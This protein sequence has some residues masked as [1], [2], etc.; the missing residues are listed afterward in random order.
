[1]GVHEGTYLEFFAKVYN[2]NFGLFSSVIISILIRNGR[3]LMLL[4]AFSLFL[5]LE[6]ASVWYNLLCSLLY[7]EVLIMDD[8]TLFKNSIQN[9]EKTTINITTNFLILLKI[10]IFILLSPYKFKKSFL[11]ILSFFYF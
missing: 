8:C 6:N 3:K 9:I 1:M 7:G 11:F 5:S 4:L 10:S 2:S